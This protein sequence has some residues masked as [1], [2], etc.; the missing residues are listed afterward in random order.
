MCFLNTF[1]REKVKLAT[2]NK[3]LNH[4]LFVFY[5]KSAEEHVKPRSNWPENG[6]V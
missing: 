2:K 6:Q 1:F 5:G 4:V 3:I